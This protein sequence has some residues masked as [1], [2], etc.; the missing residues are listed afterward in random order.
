MVLLIIGIFIVFFIGL[1]ALVRSLRLEGFKK[2]L[3]TIFSC[4]TIVLDIVALVGTL[5]PELSITFVRVFFYTG[6]GVGIATLSVAVYLLKKFYNKPFTDKTK[7]HHES[8]ARILAK[9]QEEQKK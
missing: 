2:M 1:A 8:V 5:V 9:E 6:L 4:L 3:L 7:E